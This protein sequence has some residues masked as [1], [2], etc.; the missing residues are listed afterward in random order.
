M[1][2]KVAIA[3]IRTVTGDLGGNSDRI[4][5]GIRKA[6]EEKAD[7]VL[8][9]ETAIT[10]YCCGSLFEH[11][12]FIDYN[13]KFLEKNIVPIVPKELVA[14]VGFV[15]KYGTRRD[16]TPDIYNSV[17]VIQGGK[18]V[19]TYNK[20]L[21]ANGSHHED[22][23]YFTPGAHSKTIEIEVSGNPLRIG[24][25]ICEDVWY[26]DHYRDIVSEMVS[27]GARLILCP[28][29]SYFYYGKQEVRKSLFSH[30]AEKRKVPVVTV[31]SVGVG[32]IVKNIMI[33]DG[34]S[35][36]F[37]KFGFL[38]SECKRFEEDFRIVSIDTDQEHM[39]EYYEAL[40]AKRF[41]SKEEEIFEALK[42][43]Q[44]ELFGLLGLEKAQVHMSGG[45]DSSVVLPIVVEAMGKEN[46]VAISNPTV[47]NGMTTKL[48]AQHTC[49]SLGVKL[50]WNSM[51]EPAQA[52][53]ISFND[54]FGES[55]SIPSMT[56]IHAVGRTVQALAAS[57]KF[58]TGIVA[59][60]NHTEI[61]LGWANFH[62]IGSIGCHSIIGDLTK[63]EIFRMAE[64]INERFGK[65][66]VPDNLYDG[67][68]KPAAELP[69]ANEDPFFYPAVSGICA[70]II[71]DKKETVDL[72]D[73]YRN[74]TLSTDY[75]PPSK[76]GRTI[77]DMID[78]EEF[79]KTVDMAFKRSKISVFKSAQAAPI[80]IISPTSRG[81][82]NRE[83][84]IN[85]YAGSY[86]FCENKMI[87]LEIKRLRLKI[88][89]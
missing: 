27:N 68:T 15:D 79:I 32:D 40:Q 24:V 70:E 41:S 63:T 58:K 11:P 7:I 87:P 77:Y 61:T 43:E 73:E 67:F 76:D 10:G 48:N 81:F 30:H 72:I 29:Q 16:G 17:A 34:G 53:A 65:K 23:K 39:Q 82:S 22:L 14:I 50:Y 38:M 84:I 44:K 4:V 31:N 69:D 5:A 33:Y 59:T 56:A 89:A 2:V 26:K 46:V 1:K 55:P 85:K 75:F 74:K 9:P 52:L 37:D 8:F 25:P 20:N 12:H 49:D 6:I 35:M 64:Y 13:I 86:E 80:V 57:H 47:N 83:T 66:V 78:E 36:V 51:E 21:L 19:D 71:R 88:H 60:G 3:Q 62:D 42:F 28:N 54:A 18:I 45:I